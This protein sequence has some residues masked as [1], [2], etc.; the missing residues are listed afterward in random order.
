MLLRCTNIH[1]G[2]VASKLL[3]K[4]TPDGNTIFAVIG[5]AIV[6]AATGD[7]LQRS[8]FTI[9]TMNLG[10]TPVIR[11]RDTLVYGLQGDGGGFNRGQRWKL[12]PL[13]VAGP[14][15][16]GRD[17]LPFPSAPSHT[18][19]LSPRVLGF[20]LSHFSLRKPIMAS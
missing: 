12:G 2:C 16:P 19:S 3:E 8:L 20:F 14:L 9:A 1:S 13:P 18:N 17:S 5:H 7:L 10:C 4:N 15:P 11:D 6:T